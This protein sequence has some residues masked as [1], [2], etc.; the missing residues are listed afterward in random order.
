MSLRRDPATEDADIPRFVAA[1]AP[2]D[3]EIAER[4]LAEAPRT[5]EAERR[6]D[7]RTTG[8]INAIRA[9]I[10]HPGETPERILD[11][12]A[13]RLGLPALRGATRQAMRLL[14]SHFV[15]GETIGQAI[16][17]ATAHPGFRYSFDM[18]G[19][20]ARTAPDAERYF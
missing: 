17:R 15:L 18:L 20:A 4:L 19:E 14:G 6:I 5:A 9:R 8:F 1:Y 12:L 16:K 10:V 3:E 13:K 7:A 2:P 11:S